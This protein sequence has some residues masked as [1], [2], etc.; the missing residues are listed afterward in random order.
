MVD[1]LDNSLRRKTTYE[2]QKSSS[3]YE[4]EGYGHGCWSLKKEW[5]RIIELKPR[6]CVWL[7][8]CNVMNANLLVILCSC[9]FTKLT[10]SVWLFGRLTPLDGSLRETTEPSTRW[11]GGALS[12]GGTA[13]HDPYHYLDDGRAGET[14][15]IG[16]TCVREGA[17]YPSTNRGASQAA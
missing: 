7:F 3:T 17:S 11:D 6:L 13:T 5:G 8:T 9:L 4:W 16:A 14:F 15:E 12:G 10:L 1:W 2:S